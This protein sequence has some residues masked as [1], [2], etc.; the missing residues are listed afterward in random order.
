[1]EMNF[2]NILHEKHYQNFLR[3]DKSQTWFFPMGK[4]L[5]LKPFFPLSVYNHT[6]NLCVFLY[7][8]AIFNTAY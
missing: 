1:M 2:E 4:N 8:E 7:E 6:L 3:E 5:P